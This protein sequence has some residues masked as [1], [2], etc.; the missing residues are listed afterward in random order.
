MMKKFF[1]F[2]VVLF[3]ATGLFAQQTNDTATLMISG[4]VPTI[5]D[6]AIDAN[7]AAQNL[8][9][10]APGTYTQE[11][12]ILRYRSNNNFDIT[13]SSNQSSGAAFALQDAASNAISYTITGDGSLIENNSSLLSQGRTNGQEDITL[14]IEYTISDPL[15]E[16][17]DYSDTLVFTIQG[18]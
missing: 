5:V 18:Q 16:P 15:P 14:A 13:V 4:S 2:A 9:M 8:D 7:S 1:T 10:S 11:V 6:V 12:G 3:V 17:G